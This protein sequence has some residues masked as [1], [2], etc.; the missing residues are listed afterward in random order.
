MYLV[1]STFTARK[2]FLFSENGPGDTVQKNDGRL[3]DSKCTFNV[4]RGFN[5]SEYIFNPRKFDL[6]DVNVHFGDLC[7]SVCQC[8]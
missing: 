5:A 1:P 8:T 7:D 2:A 3:R 6:R 4:V